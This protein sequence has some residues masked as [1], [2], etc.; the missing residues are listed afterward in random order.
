MTVL[1][2]AACVATAGMAATVVATAI[3]ALQIS[4]TA[5]VTATAIAGLAT[6]TVSIADQIIENGEVTDPLAVTSD[7]FES[8][9]DTAV[10]AVT[11]GGSTLLKVGK[12]IYSSMKVVAKSTYDSYHGQ[13]FQEAMSNNTNE[14]VIGSTLS[15][16]IDK[17]LFPH[18]TEILQSTLRLVCPNKN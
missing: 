2:T 7:V 8:A 1:V 12:Y 17:M 15:Y 10:N 13:D 11:S 16:S 14:Y 5:V 6:G 9:S 18:A 4:V 3:P